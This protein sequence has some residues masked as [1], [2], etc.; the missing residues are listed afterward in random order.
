M[1]RYRTLDNH[2]GSYLLLLD[3]QQQRDTNNRAF[4]R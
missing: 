2:D 4:P 1:H 3:P